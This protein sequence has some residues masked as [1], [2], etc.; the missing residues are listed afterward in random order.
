MDALIDAVY[1]AT[2]K[3]PERVRDLAIELTENQANW[4]DK[5]KAVEDYFDRP[6]F[7]YSKENVPYPAKR[8]R[9]CRSVFIRN[10]AW[11]L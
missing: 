3:L 8:S 6:E 5:V 10:K 4:Y 11:V 7:V 1:T 9:L 2:E